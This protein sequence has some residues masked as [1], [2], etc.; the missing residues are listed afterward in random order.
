M[1]VK[2]LLKFLEVT[3]PECEVYIKLTGYNP[4]VNV[5]AEEVTDLSSGKIL[6]KGEN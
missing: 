1:K 3:D 6:I 5:P 2:E 4:S